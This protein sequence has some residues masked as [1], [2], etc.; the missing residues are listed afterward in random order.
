[1]KNFACLILAAGKGTRM[2]SDMPKVLHKLWGKPMVDYILDAAVKAGVKNIVVVAGHKFELLK[3]H[4]AGKPKT[5]NQKPKIVLVRQKRLLG[6]GDA[7]ISAK[8][9]LAKAKD[10]LILYADA[11]LLKPETIKA[12]I[13]EYTRSAAALTM[14][15]AVKKDPFGYGRINRGIGDNI[16]GIIEEIDATESE[17]SIK[18]VN[19]GVYCCNA[20]ELWRALKKVKAD[21]RKKE[22]YLTSIIGILAREG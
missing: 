7:V 17:R 14:L 2:N 12:L 9:A 21:N 11:P 3:K 10:I 19:A 5:K 22:Y 4:L 13:K 15:T 20:K 1:M 18:E 8:N 6:S 16:E